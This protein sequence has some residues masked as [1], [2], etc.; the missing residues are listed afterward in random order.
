MLRQ[1]AYDYAQELW[2]DTKN[3]VLHIYD[4]MGQDLGAYYS[5]ELRLK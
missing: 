1:I 2:F 5:N 3:K 4:K